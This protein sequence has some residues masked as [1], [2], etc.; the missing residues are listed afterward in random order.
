MPQR[1]EKE[2]ENT[3]IVKKERKDSERCGRLSEKEMFRVSEPYIEIESKEE[4][5]TRQ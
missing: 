5:K 4:S 1:G 2:K 3:R